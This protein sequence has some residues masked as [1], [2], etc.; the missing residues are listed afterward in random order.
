MKTTVIL[1]DTKKPS[2]SEYLINNPVCG[3]N[4]KGTRFKVLQQCSHALLLLLFNIENGSDF[5]I[6]K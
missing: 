1:N 3:K 4:Y 2:I 6:F 5:N